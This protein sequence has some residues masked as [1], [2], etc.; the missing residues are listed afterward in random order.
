MA[1]AGTLTL[2]DLMTQT[3]SRADMLPQNYAPSLTAV[4]F[5]VTEPELISYINQSYYELYDLLVQKYGD[6]YFVAPALQFQTDGQAF[7]YPLPDGTNYSGVPAFYKILGLDLNLSPS[8]NDS[9]ITIPPSCLQSETDTQSPTCKHFM[10]SLIYATV[11][12][13]IMSGSHPPLPGDKRFVCG[14]CHALVL[15]LTLPTPVMESA[16]GQ[17]I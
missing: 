16:D 10:G 2:S 12:R 7:L 1:E 11:F 15:L 3:R 17:N 8:Q 14:M 5:F 13:E 6:D 9:F 4:N